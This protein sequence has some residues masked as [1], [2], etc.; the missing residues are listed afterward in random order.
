MAKSWEGCTVGYETIQKHR[1]ELAEKVSVFEALVAA[2]KPL[3]DRLQKIG[4]GYVIKSGPEK[5]KNVNL[6]GDASIFDDIICHRGKST[7]E[8]SL[9]LKDLKQKGM[10]FVRS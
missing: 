3:S 2:A 5:A 9:S 10:K 1:K 4:N 7:S 8:F 6:T